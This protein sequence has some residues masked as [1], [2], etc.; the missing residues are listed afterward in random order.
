MAEM[1]KHSF[2]SVLDRDSRYIIK[3]CYF[4]FSISGLFVI[5]LDTIMPLLSIEYNL[6]HTFS[7]MLISAARTGNFIAG[8]LAGILPIYIGRKNTIMLFYACLMFGLATII[9]T[10]NPYLLL[11]GFA[12][13]G[14]TRGG[15]SNFNNAVVNEVSNSSPMA[16][17][18]LHG[19]FAI[20]AIIAPLFIILAGNLSG[21]NGWRL[22]LLVIIAL[23]A[24]SVFLISK[25]KLP[26]NDV[27]GNRKQQLSYDFL[28]NRKFILSMIIFFLYYSFE[29]GVSGWLVKYFVE[30]EIIKKDLVQITASILWG[31]ILVSRFA[32]AVIGTRYSGKAML[33]TLG[34]G[35]IAF[36]VLMIATKNP[37]VIT[38][39]IAGLGLFMG[40]IYQTIISASGGI[41]KKYPMALSTIL[42]VG[43]IGGILMPFIAGVF[44]DL[45]GIF[46]GMVS[47]G[48]TG[49]LILVFSA[50]LKTSEQ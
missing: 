1:G 37:V 14:L 39:A 5:S 42:T 38:V 36:F 47:I 10:G 48:I 26:H 17:G 27:H 45:S 49:L 33:I 13:A 3:V 16:L 31:G 2:Y 19:S 22:A 28:K 21:N 46:A 50:F 29:S 18:F 35:S 15:A 25:M 32:C 34:S 8:I 20:G 11:F 23:A 43:N 44:S 40:G 4:I 24:L 12:F 9:L 30:T 41:L 6:S 7:G